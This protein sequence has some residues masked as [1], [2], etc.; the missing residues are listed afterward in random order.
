[1]KA[2]IA[3]C[4]YNRANDL[5]LAIRSGL[6]QDFDPAAFEIIVVDNRSTDHTAELVGKFSESHPSQVRYIYEENLGLSYARNRAMSE[7]RG[8]YILFLDDDAIASKQWIK[9]LLDVFE[10]DPLVGVVG[11]R[12][13]PIWEG[14]EPDWLPDEYKTL[15]TILDYSDRLTEMKAPAIPFGANV[16]FRLSMF[17]EFKPFR[18]DLGRVG[19]N[20]L[21]NEESELIGRLRQKYTVYYTPNAPVKH[22]IAKDRSTKKWFLRRIYW[23]GVSDAIRSEKK[24]NVFVKSNVKIALAGVALLFSFFNVRSRVKLMVK[25]LYGNGAIAGVLRSYKGA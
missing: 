22:K 4:T 16:A 21:S 10:S 24:T 1:M 11:G 18:V 17:K 25:I 14:G 8:E 3:I 19:T 9:G 23:Q 5:E 12:I 13:D 20:L 15:Y 6:D 7:A 2:T